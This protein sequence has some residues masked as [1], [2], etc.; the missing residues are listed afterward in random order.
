[1]IPSLS[2][3][4]YQKLILLTLGFETILNFLLV[5]L[6]DPGY[7]VDEDD[8]ADEIDQECPVTCSRRMV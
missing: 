3:N 8:F 1:M 7:V 5:T 6:I 2:A 4:Q